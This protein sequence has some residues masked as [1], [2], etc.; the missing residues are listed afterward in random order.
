MS[1]PGTWRQSYM[2]PNRNDWDT[3]FTS[4]SCDIRTVVAPRGLSFRPCKLNGIPEAPSE[5][6]TNTKTRK[7][8]LRHWRQ[9]LGRDPT[10]WVNFRQVLTLA[11]ACPILSP[12]IP[13]DATLI[14]TP[15]VTVS[16]LFSSL[17]DRRF[18]DRRVAPNWSSWK[19][20]CPILK[21]PE[22]SYMS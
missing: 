11:N 7:D 14:S 1:P 15:I 2:M 20:E 16:R 13:T 22:R 19:K 4:C 6:P 18:G 21:L 8:I 5:A 17:P 12:R 9:V 3:G 10:H